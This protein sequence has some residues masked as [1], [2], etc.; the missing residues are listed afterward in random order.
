MIEQQRRRRSIIT[1]AIVFYVALC[2]FCALSS[3]DKILQFA[4][5]LGP[6]ANLVYGTKFLAPFVIGTLFVV[7]LFVALFRAASNRRLML[8]IGFAIAWLFSGFLFYAPRA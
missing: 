6:P 8:G 5:I 7:W 4:W 1:A 3:E 2:L